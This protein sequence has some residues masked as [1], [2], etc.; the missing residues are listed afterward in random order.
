MTMGPVWLPPC[1]TQCS[2]AEYALTKRHPARGLGWQSSRISS[3]FTKGLSRWKTRLQVVCAHAFGYPPEGFAAYRRVA[4]PVSLRL[5][6]S[7]F[8][9]IIEC[10]LGHREAQ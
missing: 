4:D 6:S 10:E 1:A 5:P 8:L 7:Y 2:S 9:C 3:N